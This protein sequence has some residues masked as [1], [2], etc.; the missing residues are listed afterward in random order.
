M[1]IWTRDLVIPLK[2]SNQ[3]SYETIDFGM[4]R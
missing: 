4:M 3:L 2:R 1:E